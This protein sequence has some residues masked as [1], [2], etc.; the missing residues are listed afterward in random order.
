MVKM[1]H[2]PIPMGSKA[3]DLEL[4]RVKDLLAALDNPQN[5]LPPVIHVAGTNGKGSTI[6]FMKAIFQ[7]AGLKV[8]AYTSP[9]LINFN[10]RINILGTD[11]SD[12]FLYEVTEECRIAAEKNNIQTTFFEGTTVAAI[13]AFSRV[14][15]DVIILEVGMGG[16]LDA[17]NIIDNP[18]ISIITSISTFIYK[19]SCS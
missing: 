8:H 18:A 7:A 3:I 5:D 15:A 13:L 9:H 2:W 12:Q 14:K 16:R 10:E 1:P 4:S 11:I 6:A 17:T 19:T